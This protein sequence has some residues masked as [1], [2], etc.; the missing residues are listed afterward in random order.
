[1]LNHGCAFICYSIENLTIRAFFKREVEFRR[2]LEQDN[3]ITS[4]KKSVNSKVGNALIVERELRVDLEDIVKDDEKNITFYS[5]SRKS[6]TTN[7]IMTSINGKEFP[8]LKQFERSY[9]KIK[10]LTDVRGVTYFIHSLQRLYGN[11]LSFISAS[12]SLISVD[13]NLCDSSNVEQY[14]AE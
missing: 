6:K 14:R 2:Y 12:S 5:P 1:M 8:I 7:N 11:P 3:A 10:P 13:H 4:R 9:R